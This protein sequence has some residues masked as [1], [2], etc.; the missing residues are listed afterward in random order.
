[1]ISY[2]S[3]LLSFIL[4][5]TMILTLTVNPDLTQALILIQTVVVKFSEIKCG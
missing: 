1:M 2:P 5:P 4:T 3:T